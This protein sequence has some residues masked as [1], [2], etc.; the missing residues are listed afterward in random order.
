[1]WRAGNAGIAV[2]NLIAN[3]E[4]TSVPASSCSPEELT[5]VRISWRVVCAFNGSVELVIPE[6][7]VR[8]DPDE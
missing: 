7:V 3:L 5:L 2:I 6:I 1:M 8:P 4:D